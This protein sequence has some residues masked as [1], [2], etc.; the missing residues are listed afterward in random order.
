MIFASVCLCV[1]IV[2]SLIVQAQLGTFSQE[3]ALEGAFS[4]IVK[5][6]QTFGKPTFQ[7]LLVVSPRSCAPAGTWQQSPGHDM[8]HEEELL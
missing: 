4:V 3:M 2:F 1:S 5:S 8:I 6:L 7:A